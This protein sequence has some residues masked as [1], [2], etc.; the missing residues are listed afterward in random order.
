MFFRRPKPDLSVSPSAPNPKAPP[1]QA[2]VPPQ[3]PS[4]SQGQ[5]WKLDSEVVLDALG[6]ILRDVGRFAFDVD[7]Q[8]A[9][10][11]AHTFE[12]WSQHVTIGARHPEDDP[13]GPPRTGRDLAGA[14]RYFAEHRRREQAHVSRAVGE[15][16]QLVWSFVRSV[17]RAVAQENEA[18]N[19]TKKQ[20]SRLHAAAMTAS[21]EDLKREALAAV[22]TLDDVLKD[23]A[24][25]QQH[26]V[27][28]LRD[29]LR[30]LGRE[31]ED[32]RKEI[33]LDALTH[34]GNR[35]AFDERLTRVTE[36]GTLSGEPACLLFVDI[37]HFKQVNDR[38]GHQAGD[39]VL[40]R[41]ADALS[42]AFLRKA[43]FVGRYGGEEFAVILQESTLPVASR[44]A[45]RL[46][47]RL[48]ALDY[49]DIAL[50]L[51]VTVS[52][53]IAELAPGESHSAWLQRADRALYDAKR[54]GRD[55]IVEA[56]PPESVPEDADEPELPTM[57]VPEGIIDEMGS[58]QP[59]AR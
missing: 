18:D 26:Q 19:R 6:T 46:A 48:R 34:V 51:R 24:R 15:M 27:H 29:R 8:L 30:T 59:I 40:V 3:V 36:L 54:G 47:D 9:T 23:R 41:V 42:R 39:A 28:E 57:P 7:E 31:L 50:G 49:A 16:R 1:T 52:I 11:I 43:D 35:R 21:P 13:A 12:R 37:D 5:P 17:H 55:R 4:S 45:A 25:R 58:R 38:F 10:D 2:A 56:P 33:D 53:G 20:L 14:A 44:L 22:S 32:A